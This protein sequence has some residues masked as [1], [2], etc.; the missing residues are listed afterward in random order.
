MNRPA[1]Y[2]T[3]QYEAI[4][5]YIISLNGAHVTPAQIVD[6][7]ESR[8]IHIGRATIYRHLEKLTESGVIRRYTTDGV[9]GACYQHINNT[10]NCPEH[11]HLKCDGC[12]E[13]LHLECEK[14]SEINR[15]IFDKHNFQVDT[16][17]M[18][19]YGK[20]RHCLVLCKA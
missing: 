8:D 17:K 10:E 19:F 6:H 16:L 12:G 7:F 4:L 13:L 15:H 9:S 11:F 1:N 14:I 2:N 18:V 3:K 20:C 5:N